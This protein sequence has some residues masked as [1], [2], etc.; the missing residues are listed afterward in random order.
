MGIS[1]SPINYSVF[2]SGGCDA[3]AK[4]WD[5]RNPSVCR[6][7]CGH[8]SDINS[9]DFFGDGLAFCTGKSCSP[10]PLAS[11]HFAPVVHFVDLLPSPPLVFRF[12]R[13]LLPTL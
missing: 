9:V 10:S 12:R 8:E 6:T 2:V 5:T 11:P 4:L 7:F 1:S 3:L 13:R